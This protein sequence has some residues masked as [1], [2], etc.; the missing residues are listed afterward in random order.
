M[1]PGFRH[2]ED[3]RCEVPEQYSAVGLCS[4]APVPVLH[5]VHSQ[6]VRDSWRWEACRCVLPGRY[7]MMDYRLQWPVREQVSGR[8]PLCFQVAV[9]DWIRRAM[10]TPMMPACL[11]VAVRG[12]L[13]VCH[14][15]C[16]DRAPADSVVDWN[17]L[18]KLFPEAPAGLLI[19]KQEHSPDAMI[20]FRFLPAADPAVLQVVP[21][22][23]RKTPALEA[24]LSLP[25]PCDWPLRLEAAEC[26]FHSAA[27]NFRKR[28]FEMEP[29]RLCD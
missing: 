17:R 27:P 7:S 2:S 16:L 8:S 6:T 11:K 28:C 9:H 18:T 13:R 20:R 21:V 1:D 23:F 15:G 24:E 25:R 10:K 3:G 4:P 22:G 19:L 29:L 12:P 5:P 14:R 26:V